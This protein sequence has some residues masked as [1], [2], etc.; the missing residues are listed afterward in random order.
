MLKARADADTLTMQQKPYCPECEIRELQSRI[1]KESIA[2]SV[3]RM[4]TVRGVTTEAG[5]YERRLAIC[6]RCP[7]L[8]SDI[9]CAECGSYVAYRARIASSSCPFPGQDKWATEQ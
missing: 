9:L 7:S 5:E 6:G 2:A 3:A 8:R 1:T 4:A